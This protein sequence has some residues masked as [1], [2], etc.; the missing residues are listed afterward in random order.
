MTTQERKAIPVPPAEPRSPI[1]AQNLRIPG[2]TRLA[3]G[4]R[5][6]LLLISFR[7]ATT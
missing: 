6:R 7:R 3:R 2:P 5:K 4:D 1:P